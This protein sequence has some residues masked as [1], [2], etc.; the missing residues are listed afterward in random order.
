MF[1]LLA[2]S[3]KRKKVEGKEREE[4]KC[5][6]GSHLLSWIGGGWVG[7]GRDEEKGELEGGGRKKSHG[8]AREKEGEGGG[9]RGE[10]Y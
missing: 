2:R 1:H 5:C 7:Y 10:K 4:I 9:E 6:S 3:R 8:D